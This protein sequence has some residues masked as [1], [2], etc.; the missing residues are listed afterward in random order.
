[1]EIPPELETAEQRQ[2]SVERDLALA[3]RA[4]RQREEVSVE[5][6]RFELTRDRVTFAFELALVLATLL[7]A[8]VVI[9]R[10]PELAPVFLLGGGG[11][12]GA[13]MRRQRKSQEGG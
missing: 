2:D 5:R 7:V 6:D 11:I 10:N 3:I 1:V 4:A 12:G 8:V 13:L 9:A